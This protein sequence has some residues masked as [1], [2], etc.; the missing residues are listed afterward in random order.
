MKK[1]CLVISLD[2][3]L[4]WGIFDHVEI[5]DKVAY[6]NNT[7]EAIPQIL[8][9]F[10]KYDVH[11]TWA[12][13]GMLFN[14]NWEE[15][16]SN[17]PSLL[18]TYDNHKL[19]PYEYGKIHQKSGFNQYFFAPQQVRSIQSLSGQELGTHTYSHYYCLEKGQTKEQFDADLLT[20]KKMATNFNTELKSLVFPRNQFNED[21][22]EI[23][24]NHGILS[25]RSNPEDWYWDTTAPETLMMKLA[26]S[27]DAYFPIGKKSYQSYSSEL[28]SVYCQKASRFL[29]PQSKYEILNATRLIRI[30]KEIVSAAKNG[31]VYH[32]WWHPHNFGIDTN[33]ALKALNEILEIFK[34]CRETYGMTNDTMN[35]LRE[36]SI[37][38]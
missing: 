33:G 7:L 34:M 11:A 4:V 13:V 31:E 16:H 23:C 30:K 32:L 8:D 35:E 20:A 6:F 19:N 38:V 26:R 21:Y 27:G 1:G 2:F 17:I 12:T 18:P 9:L 5:K 28:N 14:K 25:V 24:K 29:R 15:W 36:N 37:N 22:L 3:E 10:D